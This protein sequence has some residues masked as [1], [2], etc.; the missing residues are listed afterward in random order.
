MD[1]Q[2]QQNQP[3]KTD[4]GT[5]SAENDL[6]KIKEDA[7]KIQESDLADTVKSID[8]ESQKSYFA[9]VFAGVLM[10]LVR[11][12]DNVPKGFACA[13]IFILFVAAGIAFYNIS[14]KKVAIHADVSEIFIRNS[15]TQWIDHIINKHVFLNGAYR[16]ASNLLDKKSLLTKWSFLLLIAAMFFAIILKLIYA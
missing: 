2:P 16:N 4:E 9:L 15:P 13:F 5:K 12:F 11:D 14:S 1:N 8:S 3:Q 7:V 6:V 10:A